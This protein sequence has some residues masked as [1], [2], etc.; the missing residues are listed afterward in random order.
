[1][2]ETKKEKITPKKAYE[3]DTR[4]LHMGRY[5]TKGG[6]VYKNATI[7]DDYSDIGADTEK[8]DKYLKAQERVKILGYS[9]T[10][11]LMGSDKKIRSYN[12]QETSTD[13]EKYITYIEKE[14]ANC[15]YQII[16]NIRK[17][18]SK[19]IEIPYANSEVE[20]RN[21][22]LDSLKKCNERF[23]GRNRDYEHYEHFY[24]GNEKHDYT[25]IPPYCDDDYGRYYG[26][27]F[28][29][30]IEIYKKLTKGNSLLKD[31]PSS[32]SDEFKWI[33]L[34]EQKI[35]NLEKDREK[36][37]K[38]LEKA[39]KNEERAYRYEER[40][41]KN[42]SSLLNDSYCEEYIDEYFEQE[43]KKFNEEQDA[44]GVDPSFFEDVG[45]VKFG[46]EKEK[47]PSSVLLEKA[48]TSQKD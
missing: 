35:N 40:F 3:R 6:N 14:I 45:D 22:C 38:E 29:V 12:S 37:E 41:D 17:L 13:I 48:K 19:N 15:V 36:L 1:M 32:L 7:E 31:I 2:P 9:P 44:E 28:C 25:F 33:L 20:K 18:E 26:E 42:L 23:D 5:Y 39:V 27:L 30:M 47:I 46:E 11:Q 8:Y 24:Y 16:C 21:I 43:I 34:L 10:V 4:R